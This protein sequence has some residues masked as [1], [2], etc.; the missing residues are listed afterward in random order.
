MADR[1]NA[2]LEAYFFE[3][4]VIPEPN[5]GCWLWVGATLR[6]GYGN[7]NLNYS[8]IVA[9]RAMWEFRHEME[10]PR[11]LLACHTC[12][13]PSCVN[14]DHVWPGTCQ[15]NTADRIAKGRTRG[16][17][18]KL[19]HSVRRATVSSASEAVSDP[20]VPIVLAMQIFKRAYKSTAAEA[21]DKALA[22]LLTARVCGG[23]SA[24]PAL[25]GRG[26]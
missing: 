4:F 6:D 15:N 9:H 22:E 7:L 20:Q 24:P 19:K 13:T 21:S 23:A 2:E 17:E 16:F 8:N 10:M 14:P 12:D 3:K 26:A 11:D 25:N 1:T 5:S 18:F